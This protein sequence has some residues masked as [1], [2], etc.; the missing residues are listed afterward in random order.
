VARAAAEAGDVDFGVA[1]ARG[2]DDPHRRADLLRDV[3]EAAARGG[4]VDGAETVARDIPDAKQRMWTLGSIARTVADAGNLVAAAEL[5]SSAAAVAAADEAT[6]S[7]AWVYATTANLW[8]G[9]LDAAMDFA[10]MIVF[11]AERAELLVEVAAAMVRSGDP[12]RARDVIAEAGA[13]ARAVDKIGP[14]ARALVG[15]V[16]AATLAGDTEHARRLTTEVVALARTIDSGDWDRT[17]S[18]AEL[19][20]LQGYTP[21][22]RRTFSDPPERDGIAE[23]AAEIAVRNGD[24]DR[25]GSLALAITDP[26]PRARTITMVALAAV[27]AGHVDLATELATTAE[28][29]ATTQTQSQQWALAL[30]DAAGAVAEAGDLDR[31]RKLATAA[32]T[33]ARATV[34]PRWQAQALAS[35]AKAL[36]QAG[37]RERAMDIV[38]DV[39][40]LAETFADP[41]DRQWVYATVAKA[42]AHAGETERALDVAHAIT[43]RLNRAPVL[44]TII[45][46]VA[47]TGDLA[48]ARGL[49]LGIT[50][51]FDQQRAIVAAA[52]AAALAGHREHATVLARDAEAMARDSDVRTWRATTLAA[53]VTVVAQ[54]GDAGYAHR[55]VRDAAAA[56]RSLPDDRRADRARSLAEVAQTAARTGDL[57]HAT[58]LVHEAAADLQQD[59]DSWALQDIVVAATLAGDT[60]RADV[61]ARDLPRRLRGRAWAQAAR[62]VPIAQ[63][64][65]LL[66][67]ALRLADWRDAV[68]AIAIVE[69]AVLTEI[70]RLL[71]AGKSSG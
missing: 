7:R 10:G 32:E 27:R 30:A 50:D 56:A 37:S 5:A 39:R 34:E 44:Y 21:E 41:Q 61:L 58:T 17:V 8:K 28:I 60:D 54:A 24:L 3:A 47:R 64:R 65:P 67:K 52:R 2:I 49:V 31:A 4:H 66:A 63:A 1:V 13:T 25:A 29:T 18:A 12:G 40:L 11:P 9:D 19:M 20:A 16:K 68:D 33:F 46:T 69:P 36:A 15:V 14:R 57:D 70:A 22:L 6:A 53:A 42:L 51:P 43:N 23:E 26:E 71:L 38:V 59:A 62:F 55:L 45:A 35:A 48:H